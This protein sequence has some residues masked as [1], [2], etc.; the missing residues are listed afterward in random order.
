M[1]SA[2]RTVDSRCEMSTTV[3]SPRCAAS[4]PNTSN[5]VAHVQVRGRL[6][7]HQQLGAGAHRVERPGQH[8]LLPLAA[9]QV[10]PAG[11]RPGQRGVPA[12][13]QPVEH[14]VEAGIAGR[15]AR[16]GRVTRGT[17]ALPS[18]TLSAADRW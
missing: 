6:V 4:R 1:R 18:A 15:G 5:S 9:G 14:L 3:A 11:A 13:R 7:E 17:A 12:V 2:R 10:H 8:D 16:G